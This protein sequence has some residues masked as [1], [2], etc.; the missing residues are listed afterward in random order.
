MGEGENNGGGEW[1][2]GGLVA[3]KREGRGGAV[4]QGFGF[5]LPSA[6]MGGKAGWTRSPPYGPH[7]NNEGGKD[8]GREWGAMVKRRGGSAA[9]V[10][11]SGR[12]ARS[13]P[14]PERG[15][16][17]GQPHWGFS[18]LATIRS[19]STDTGITLTEGAPCKHSSQ[20]N[21]LSTKKR[22]KISH[23]QGGEGGQCTRNGQRGA[24]QGGKND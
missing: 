23:F 5:A 13:G 1:G 11:V 22:E 24:G 8:G 21:K 17:V 7:K 18:P 14:P 10:L 12:I 16:M 4:T 9:R 15:L 19:N 20:G 3:K 2:D 6:K